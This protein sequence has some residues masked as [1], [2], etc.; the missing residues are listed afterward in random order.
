MGMFTN[1]ENIDPYYIPNN[2]VSKEFYTYKNVEDILP[3]TVYNIKGNP[4]GL[5]WVH[6]EEFTLS[7]DA[8][9][10]IKVPENSIVYNIAGECPN[11]ETKGIDG[12]QAY[13]T[14]DCKSWT[15]VGQGAGFYIWVEDKEF[16]YIIAKNNKEITLQQDFK[17]TTLNLEIY[18]FR[19]EL[20]FDTNVTDSSSIHIPVDKTL[21]ELLIPGVYYVLLKLNTSQESIVKYKNMLIVK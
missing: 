10:V 18:N 14:V 17:D 6:G 12:Q 2:S 5:S 1:Y 15:C 4:V 9:P 20:I 21:N 19:W 13:N 3:R 11:Y 8:N 7:F 16:T